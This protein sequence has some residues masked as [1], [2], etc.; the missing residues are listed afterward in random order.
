VAFLGNYT[1]QPNVDAAKR[2]AVDVMPHLR[3]RHT[4]V[5]LALA[6]AHMPTE[7]LGEAAAD[8]E[9]RGYVVDADAFLG[10][11][12][13]VLAPVREGGGM[14][15]K[16]LHAMALGRPVVTTSL[17]AEGLG[18][19]APLVVVDDDDGLARETARLLDDAD[20]RARLGARARAY[21]AEQHSP[22]AYARRL[23]ALCATGSAVSAA[24]GWAGR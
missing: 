1:H 16:V 5:Q 17:G 21:A 20:A 15:M 2:L 18:P 12:A 7:I 6:G 13:V 8:I 9:V 10:E 23:E 14:R 4:G 19:E 3:R 24:A 11:A 22:E